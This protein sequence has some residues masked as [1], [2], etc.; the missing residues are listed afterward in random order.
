MEKLLNEVLDNCGVLENNINNLPETQKMPFYKTIKGKLDNYKKK[1]EINI[2][3]SYEDK[4][5]LYEDKKN[6][7]IDAMTQDVNNA[8]SLLLT[9]LNIGVSK[10][11]KTIEPEFR[12]Q[13]WKYK[14]GSN[15]NISCYM[16]NNTKI[17]I[18]NFTPGQII[19]GS[20][21]GSYNMENLTPIC[22]T[23]DNSILLK[24]VNIIHH[25][26]TLFPLT[27]YSE[28]YNKLVKPYNLFHF[29]SETQKIIK[30]YDINDMKENMCL[31]NS[32]FEVLNKHFKGLLDINIMKIS[33]I[34]IY[35]GFLDTHNIT[36][37]DN[38]KCYNLNIVLFFQYLVIAEPY[39][40]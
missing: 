14:Y 3:Q 19:P 40:A 30:S 21:G 4:K 39:P 17:S 15:E 11:K 36:G 16:C 28:L 32:Q 1:M 9:K 22:R 35:D 7:D 8:E 23:C 25:Y 24:S 34:I 6:N 29:D 37:I 10:R 2:K 26:N 38:E 18:D 13:L 27:N 12:K 5:K 20:K 31:F 33:N